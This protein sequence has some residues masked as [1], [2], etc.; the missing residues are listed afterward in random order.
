LQATSLIK[1]LVPV[2]ECGICI[3][4]VFV[5]QFLFLQLF[6][7][8][9]PFIFLFTYIFF[10]TSHISLSSEL[11]VYWVSLIDITFVNEILKLDFNK[12]FTGCEWTSKEI[13]LLQIKAF[14]EW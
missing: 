1:E 8:F 2:R 5:I 7:G 10:Q 13:V 4:A 3:L 11:T 9:G 12:C 6:I 14:Q